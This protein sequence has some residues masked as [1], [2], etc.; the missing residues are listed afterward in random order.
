M[1]TFNRVLIAVALIVAMALCSVFLVIPAAFDQLTRQLAVVDQFLSTLKPVA[2]VGFG[3]L[4]A[5]V[6]DIVLALL[7]VLELRRARP[8]SIR[9]ERVTGGEVSI[10]TASIV[11][12]LR[13]EIDQ[14][15]GV[16]RVRPRVTARRG[17][18]AVRLDIE[19][20]VAIDVPQKA[21]RIV[22]TAHLVIEE[23]MGLKLAHPPKVELRTVAHPPLRPGR[24]LDRDSQPEEAPFTLAAG[25][26]SRDS[27][28]DVV[29][30]ASG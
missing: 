26:E 30:E 1:N 16:L 18:V 27:G 19:T 11:D 4:F 29:G 22:E 15:P 14:L 20:A 17:G 13:Y 12:R 8:R 2:R 24:L 21:E 25:D 5:A 9:V 3:V 28:L 10:S 7:V 23:K 6:L